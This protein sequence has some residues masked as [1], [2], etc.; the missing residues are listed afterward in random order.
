LEGLKYIVPKPFKKARGYSTLVK[1]LL[2]VYSSYMNTIKAIIILVVFS[3]GLVLGHN[4]FVKNAPVEEVGGELEMVL[5]PQNIQVKVGETQEVMG[6]SITLNGVVQ[7]V[8]C[9]VDVECVEAGAINTDITLSV[10]DVTE[11]VFYAS[12]GIP[13][14][15]QDYEISIVG[16]SPELISTETIDP[17]EYVVTFN[18]SSKA[19]DFIN[20]PSS[21][22]LFGTVPAGTS[23]SMCIAMGGEWSEDFQECLGIGGETC[24]EIGGT[25]NECASACRNNPDAEVCTMQCVQVCEFKTILQ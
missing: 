3:V 4:Y 1:G 10:G 2:F 20:V 19:I 13:L 14:S 11:T 12:D 17:S 15:F 8:R 18:V 24:Q 21:E 7:D 16:V 23:E 22:D 6:V 5:P 25:W 9:P